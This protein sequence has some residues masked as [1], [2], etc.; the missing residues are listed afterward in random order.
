MGLSNS[1]VEPPPT[2]DNYF[3]KVVICSNFTTYNSSPEGGLGR[4]DLSDKNHV[5]LFSFQNFIYDI[6]TGYFMPTAT[7][8]GT[9]IFPGRK[10]D[11]E[12][13]AYPILLQM[14]NADRVP[15][16]LLDEI[17]L[18][19]GITK[20]TLP[21]VYANLGR[22]LFPANEQDNWKSVFVICGE[23]SKNLIIDLLAYILGEDQVQHVSDQE[24]LTRDTLKK[25]LLVCDIE[26]SPKLTIRL[27][28]AANGELINIAPENQEPIY[29][30]IH[31]PCLFTCDSTCP[32]SILF[33]QTLSEIDMTGMR[34]RLLAEVSHILPKITSLYRRY[35]RKDCNVHP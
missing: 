18:T 32:S 7:D 25:R 19:Q 33:T 28:N 12:F 6:G 14:K 22:L 1:K 34:T 27:A 5:N 10:I 20:E 4:V 35:V 30:R 21:I 13:P 23:N 31:V 2:D 17:L 11:L 16:P 15:T 29:R 26:K 8:E 24:P 3:K 9:T